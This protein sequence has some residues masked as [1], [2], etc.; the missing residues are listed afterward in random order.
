MESAWESVWEASDRIASKTDDDEGIGSSMAATAQ[1]DEAD[2]AGRLRRGLPRDLGGDVALGD[3]DALGGVC[4]NLFGNC[5][6][7]ASGNHCDSS[8]PRV[9]TIPGT[10]QASPLLR[11]LGLFG[12][13]R[14]HAIPPG[15]LRPI[16]LQLG[17]SLQVGST[18]APISITHGDSDRGVH[19]L[20]LIHI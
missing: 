7:C 13:D 18:H 17:G 11:N 12:H 10:A 5:V 16:H 4:G 8:R 1:G 14:A 3:F 19:T 20:S 9:E 2:H 6:R 15:L